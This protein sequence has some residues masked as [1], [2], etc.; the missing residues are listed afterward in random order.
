MKEVRVLKLNDYRVVRK[1]A[2]VG[3]LVQEWIRLFKNGNKGA[4]LMKKDIFCL[5]RIIVFTQT[6]HE[7]RYLK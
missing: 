1:K 5:K 4:G 6:L 3:A 7:Y 2:E